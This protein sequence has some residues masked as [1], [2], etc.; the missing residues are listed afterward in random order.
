MLAP[1]GAR[2]WSRSAPTRS[3]ASRP[4][5]STPG[6]TASL[7]AF[8]SN[9]EAVAERRGRHLPLPRQRRAA[10]FEPPAGAV[11]VDLSGAHR[12]ADPELA[13]AGVVRGRAEGVELRPARALSAPEG[14]L[15]ANPG[16]YAT[17]A[18]LA[19]APDRG[20]DRP[21]RDRR[22][23]VGRVRCRQEL[24]ASSHAGFVL[25][26]FSPYAVGA[27]RHAPEIAQALGFPVCFV[28]H[29]LP[30]GA[31]SS[32]PVTSRRTPTARAARRT[33]TPTARSSASSPRGSRRSSRACRAPTRPRSASSPTARPERRS[34]ICAL[35]NLGKGAAG[36]AMQNANLALGLARR[37][38]CASTE[39]S[40]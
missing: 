2:S 5:P 1:S 22:R 30:S 18:L 3:R 29:L 28:P 19:L 40:V 37:P 25:E 23:Q 27:H 9:D 24:K 16:C 33:P 6:S 11:V 10:A 32:P 38:G 36:Q 7:P 13:G 39:C 8:V 26:N 34:S 31:A 12:L 21:R 20:R 15:I 14:P 17:A 4:A 35:D